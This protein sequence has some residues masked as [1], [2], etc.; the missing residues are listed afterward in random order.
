MSGGAADKFSYYVS[1]G[2]DDQKGIFNTSSLKRY[3][4][5]VNLTQKALD[6]RFNVDFN[7]TASRTVN[8]R[9]DIGGMTVDML[10]LNPTI[11]VYTNGE[12]TLFV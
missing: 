1:T 3:S 9:P 12:P 6:G 5:R 2:V 11:P 4:G 7:L 10:Q 8:D